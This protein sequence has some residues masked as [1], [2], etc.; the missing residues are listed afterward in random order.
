MR[1]EGGIFPQRSRPYSPEHVRAIEISRNRE[2]N[3]RASK[4]ALE[5]L[6]TRPQVDAYL[7]RHGIH[8]AEE[9]ME[10]ERTLVNTLAEASYQGAHPEEIKALRMEIW[11]LSDD[12]HH[13]S[14]I[15]SHIATDLIRKK[16]DSLTERPI[17]RRGA[18]SEDVLD[19]MKAVER[20]LELWH[21]LHGALIRKLTGQNLLEALRAEED[22]EHSDSSHDPLEDFEYEYARMLQEATG[23]YRKTQRKESR[24]ELEDLRIIRDR[25]YYNLLFPER[26][27]FEYLLE[28]RSQKTSNRQQG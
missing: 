23:H 1:Q 7:E 5:E 26:A 13:T 19:Q 9:R 12:A 17:E 15:P 11:M 8:T 24:R 16:T 6:P 22:V 4:P 10:R 25:L 21:A 3:E 14:M 28:K 27:N 2:Q 18:N 20:E